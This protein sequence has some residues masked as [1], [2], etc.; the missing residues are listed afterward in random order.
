[1][2]EAGAIERANTCG[3]AGIGLRR[4]LYMQRPS[5][6]HFRGRD[7]GM[8]KARGA[9]AGGGRPLAV[10]QKKARANRKLASEVGDPLTRETPRRG[11]AELR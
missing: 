2:Q 10:A 7:R 1:M 4:N 8:P 11:R 3:N 6:W 9:K 5:A